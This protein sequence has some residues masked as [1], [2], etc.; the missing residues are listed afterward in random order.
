M[1]ISDWSSDVC[2][3]DLGEEALH[4]GHRITAAGLRTGHLL[5]LHIDFLAREVTARRAID[6]TP[7]DPGREQ[8][9]VLVDRT[10][11]R[12]EESRVGKECVSPGRS[13]WVPYH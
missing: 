11:W 12:S 9:P 6:E 10:G 4:L 7:L 8:P 3:S 5:Q 1:R 2:S 13:R